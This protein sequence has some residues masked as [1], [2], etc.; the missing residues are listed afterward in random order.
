MLRYFFI[1]FILITVAIVSLAGFR[2]EK[3]PLP[4]VQIFP[5]MKVQP[6]YDPQHTSTFF[7]DGSARRV[8]YVKNSFRIV[9]RLK[10]KVGMAVKT[11]IKL[12]P[13]L[14]SKPLIDKTRPF[15]S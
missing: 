6:R 8:F 12:H 2:G 11:F 1:A 9:S 4:P 13:S 5:D 15:M 3:S 10:A 14:L 7:A